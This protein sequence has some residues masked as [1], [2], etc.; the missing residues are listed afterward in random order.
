ML[1]ILN[2][3]LKLLQS[4]LKVFVKYPWQILFILAL[5]VMF[6]MD[7]C[8]EPCPECPPQLPP[9][10]LIHT[11]TIYGD[12]IYTLQHIYHYKDT[13]STQ[14]VEVPLN[15]D[16][17][18]V[19]IAYYTEWVVSDTILKDTNGLIIITDLL[20]RN[21]IQSRRV[22]KEFYPNYIQVTKVIHLDPI[23]RNI[24]YIG[25][26]VNGWTDKMG[27]TAEISLLN[28]RGRIW[29]AS[30]DPLNNIIGLSTQWPI[31]FKH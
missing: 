29:N 26:G 5:V 2:T 12:T 10:T 21:R 7:T 3:L 15:I 22:Y 30:Y 24:L 16:S 11:D 28:K 6:F 27:V 17:L 4:F 9:D 1:P 20:S 19:A 8:Q 25:F 14:F 18:A 23:P 31:R 13:G